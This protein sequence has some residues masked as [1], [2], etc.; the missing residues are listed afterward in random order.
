MNANYLT[1]K[2]LGVTPGI[3]FFNTQQAS[4]ICSHTGVEDMYIRVA[5]TASYIASY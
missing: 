1:P 2:P 3:I 4:L 5:T